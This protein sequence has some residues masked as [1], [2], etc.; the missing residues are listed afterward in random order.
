[1][2]TQA[3]HV[4][5]DAGT[6]AVDGFDVATQAADVR[7]SISLTGQFAAV[8]E[9]LTGRGSLVL[10]ARLRRVEGPGQVADDLLARFQ[11]IDAA[12]RRV[13]T[14]SGGMR[15]RLDLAMSLVGNPPVIVLNEPIT[16]LDPRPASRY[17]TASKSSPG[18]AR[19]CCS[20][21][22]IWRRPSSW[23]TGSRSSTRGGSRQ[24]HPRPAQTA[25]PARQGRVRREAADPRR[26]LP[27]H[28][29]QRHRA[30]DPTTAQ[31]AE[32]GSTDARIA[33]G[34]ER[35]RGAV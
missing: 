21:P 27:R 19:R 8:D 3:I 33:G 24:R 28:H 5:S 14:Y 13:A 2:T 20:P 15:R 12:K 16:G 29:R 9:T 26:R 34:L 11:L 7:E 23:P 25:S 4:Q 22:S 6:A 10:V 30:D 35:L 17:G 31:T 32:P 18:R 1:M